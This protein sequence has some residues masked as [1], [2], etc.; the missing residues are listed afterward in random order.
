ML[1]AV[2]PESPVRQVV[3]ALSASR[4]FTQRGNVGIEVLD[5][6]NLFRLPCMQA[7]PTD[8]CPMPPASPEPGSGRGIIDSPSG[9]ARE[10]CGPSRSIAPTA[11]R[12]YLF[13]HNL[14][15]VSIRH[16]R[17]RQPPRDSP[18]IGRQGRRPVSRSRRISAGR[19]VHRRRER[20][21]C[22]G[23]S[24]RPVPTP[25]TCMAAT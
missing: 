4:L 9:P 10:P 8:P 16:D 25:D 15:S 19:S 21:L 3:P 22:R 20:S 24:W 6:R 12:L 13:L 7:P 17:G 18:P 5:P 1:R 11:P 14:P 23:P 2:R